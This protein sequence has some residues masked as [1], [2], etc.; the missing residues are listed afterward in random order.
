MLD[1]VRAFEL[2]SAS[3]V[4][5]EISPR[6]PGDIAACYANPALAEKL[7]D[8]KAARDLSAMCRDHWRWQVNNPQG[9]A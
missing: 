9:Y 4:P 5:H 8:W 6:R 3:S 7:L 2:A 1:V